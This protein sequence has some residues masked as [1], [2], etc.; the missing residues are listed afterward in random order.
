MLVT[1]AYV[2]M[3]NLK[4]NPLRTGLTAVAFAFPMAVFVVAISLVL[5]LIRVSF[6]Q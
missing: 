2:L 5:A 3:Q 1:T 6:G 4:R